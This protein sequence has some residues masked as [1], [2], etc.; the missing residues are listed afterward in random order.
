MPIGLSTFYEALAWTIT[1]IIV[2]PDTRFAQIVETCPD[3]V[4]YDIGIIVNKSP[5]PEGIARITLRLP[6]HA[7]RIALVIGSMLEDH[8]VVTNHVEHLCMWVVDFPIAV[9]CTECLCDGTCLIA[10][11]DGS[12]QLSCRLDHANLL[13]LDHFVADTPGDDTG[14][15]AIAQHHGVGVFTIAGVDEG[16]VVVGILLCAPAVEGFADNQHAY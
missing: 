2:A 7:F 4:A 14:V 3:D 13:A 6:H 16:R 11:Q 1:L 12:L 10:L 9:P 5:V 8:I 15:I